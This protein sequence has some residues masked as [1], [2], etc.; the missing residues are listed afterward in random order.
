MT[1]SRKL[2]LLFVAALLLLGGCGGGVGDPPPPPTDLPQAGT[3]QIHKEEDG[4]LQR[5]IIP[6][7]FPASEVPTPASLKELTPEQAAS[8]Y[9]DS[10]QPFPMYA[11]GNRVQGMVAIV[12]FDMQVFSAGHVP[13]TY[14]GC[15]SCELGSRVTFEV[16]Y[17]AN[18]TWRM[19]TD[20]TQGGTRELF[21]VRYVYL[22]VA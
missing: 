21:V 2:P 5:P 14:S 6:H 12:S 10:A 8:M 11:Q 17:D 18:P 22:R 15:G 20:I 19:G 9:A 7:Q 13:F 4:R 3:W 1:N 16:A